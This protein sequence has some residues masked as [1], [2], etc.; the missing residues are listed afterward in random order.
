MAGVG[1]ALGQGAV[2]GQEQQPLGVPVQPPHGVDPDPGVRHKVGHD[3]SPPLI[4]EGGDVAPG[5]WSIR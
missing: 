4:R 2:V 1:Q 3:L 5:L